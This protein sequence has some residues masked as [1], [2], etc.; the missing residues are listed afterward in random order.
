MRAPRWTV[1]LFTML[2]TLPTLTLAQKSKPRKTQ[3]SRQPSYAD[4]S[5]PDLYAPVLNDT[6]QALVVTASGWNAVDGSLQR[7]EKQEGKWVTVGEKIAV[8]LGKNGLA[9]D[10]L[11]EPA[12]TGAPLKQEGDGRSPAGIF[13]LG[14]AFGFAVSH[15]GL[16]L[17]YQPLTAS[18]EC[19]DDP[20]SSYYNQI[21][22]RE[23]VPYPNWSSSEKMASIAAYKE[24]AVVEYN[25]DWVP[26]A[27]SC[28]FL[29]IWSG[30]GHGTAGCT[31]MPEDKLTEVLRWLDASKKPVLIQ[32]PA[33]M[34][35]DVKTS[36][37]LP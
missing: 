30:S 20:N 19:I 3:P 14:D 28:I 36:W 27:G 35:N 24:G 37:K 21:V 23:D 33:A 6:S 4:F 16:K 8:V 26:G 11:A 29:H 13:S 31:A 18:I 12:P 1:V 22:N 2:L 9:W 5:L 15:A 7:Y 34:Y 17:P 32:L 10:A 25:A